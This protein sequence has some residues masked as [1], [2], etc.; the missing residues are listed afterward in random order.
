MTRTLILMRHAKSSWDD[1]SL[2]DHARPLNARGIASARAMGD[3][4]REKGH[5]PDAAVSS[6]SQRTGQTFTELGFDIPVTYTRALYHAGPEMM[7][8]V[9]QGQTAQIVLMLGHNPGIANVAD[10]LV[11]QPPGHPRFMDY[12]TCATTVMRFDA[13]TWNDIG[14]REGQPIDFAIPREVMG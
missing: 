3:W 14:W 9:L 7:M 8:E 13:D 10:R 12:P 11:T 4:L 5:V 1:P 6:D 2:S